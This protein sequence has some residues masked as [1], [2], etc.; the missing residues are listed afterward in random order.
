MFYFSS[1][2]TWGPARLGFSS[3]CGNF[4]DFRG[5]VSA[6]AALHPGR[7]GPPPAAVEYTSG[8][9]AATS[10]SRGEA[11]APPCVVSQSDA[12]APGKGRSGC[13]L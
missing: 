7:D 8:I 4:A 6:G 5:L 11:W 12:G 1:C 10:L 9:S 2:V 13:E 3:A